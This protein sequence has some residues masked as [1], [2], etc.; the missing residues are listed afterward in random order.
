MEQFTSMDAAP[1]K[2]QHHQNLF[3]YLMVVRIFKYTLR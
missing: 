3:E 1:F 2:K